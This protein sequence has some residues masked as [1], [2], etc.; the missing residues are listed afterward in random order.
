MELGQQ[1]Y[2]VSFLWGKMPKVLKIS[3]IVSLVCT[4]VTSG[5]FNLCVL[6]STFSNNYKMD[7][8]HM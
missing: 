7:G 6:L 5:M 2:E 3:L 4:S 1:P 8:D